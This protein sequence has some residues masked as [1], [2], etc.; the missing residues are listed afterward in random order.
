[1]K[2][3]Y[4]EIK[5]DKDKD[6]F[7]T[8][9]NFLSVLRILLIIPII[10]EL[11]LKTPQ[12]YFYSFVLI[13]IAYVTDFLDGWIAR[14]THTVSRLGQLLDPIGDKLIAITLSAAFFLQGKLPF[15]FFILIVLRDLIISVGALY[16]MKFKKV[17][18]LPLLW[19]KLNTL[20][21]GIV[22][23]VYPLRFSFL[24]DGRFPWLATLIREVVD[25]GIWVSSVLIILSG[26]IYS[27]NFIINFQSK[28]KEQKGSQDRENR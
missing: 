19:G 12:S 13:G 28:K 18:M 14:L 16:A 9:P 25:K 17:I 22:L 6:L 20:V 8:V 7:W 24:M 4:E 15:F 10:Y 3:N 21:L 5:P 26:T 11:S 27:V 23:S 1:M 2:K